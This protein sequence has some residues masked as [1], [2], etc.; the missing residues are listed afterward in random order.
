MNVLRELYRGQKVCKKDWDKAC[1]IQLIDSQLLF[2]STYYTNGSK[3]KGEVDSTGEWI[4]Y[5]PAVKELTIPEI[6]YKLGYKIKVV[7]E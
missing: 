5:E 3:V 4:V 7:G 6:E 2:L 1:Y